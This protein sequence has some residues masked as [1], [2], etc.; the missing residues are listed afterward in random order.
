MI[1]KKPDYPI[2]VIPKLDGLENEI[3][4]RRLFG[5]LIDNKFLV[6]LC[7]AV[8][9]LFGIAYGVLSTPI[10]KSSAL[11][12][13]EDNSSGVLALDDIG[14]MFA[15]N[16][17]VDTELYILKSRLVLGQT[18]DELGLDTVIRPNYFPFVGKFLSRSNESSNVLADPL[19]GASYAWGGEKLEVSYLEVPEYLQFEELTLVTEG[20][21]SYSLWYDGDKLLTGQV[22]KPARS[23]EFD[24]HIKISK[25]F[26]HIGTEFNIIKKSRLAAIM[27]L[28]KDFIA[29]SLGKDTGIMELS[30][31]GSKRDRISNILN[32]ISSNY[33]SQ[34]VLRLAAEAENSLSFIENQLPKVKTSLVNSEVALNKY[35][36]TR[37]SVDL[38]LETESLLSG[39]VKLESEISTMTL[40]ESEISRRF[41]VQ[42]P[43][44]QSF[45]RQQRDL[46]IQRDQLDEKINGLPETQQKILTLMRDFEVN[47]AIYL[48]LQSKTQELSIVKASMVGNVRVLDSAI[49]YPEADSPK[50]ALL[51]LM[52]TFFGFFASVTY[53]F[54]K[55]AL[56]RGIKNSEVLEANGFSVFGTIPSSPAQNKFDT[57]NARGKVNSTSP[58]KPFLLPI[59]YPAD[60]S[61]EALRAVRTALHFAMLEA[62]NK[63]IMI[64][65]GTQGVGKSF[66]SQNLAIVLAQLGMKVLLVDADLRR[67][68]IHKNFGEHYSP[69][70]SDYLFDVKSEISP[71]KTNIN[72]LDLLPRGALHEIPSELLMSNRFTQLLDILKNKYDYILVDTPPALAVTDPSIIGRHASINLVVAR[73]EMT[74]LKEIQLSV[75]RLRINGVKVDGVIFNGLEYSASNHYAGFAKYSY[76]YE[77]EIS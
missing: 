56:D 46:I 20:A 43:A 29:K 38:T 45:K 31:Y 17:S 16:S 76:T 69:G 77:S 34:N 23:V 32:S 61:V 67:G 48:S 1:D 26:A 72:N 4:L 75:D 24:V 33:V 3:D 40:N 63:I 36:E 70:L 55:S 71:L 15:S 6:V 52:F 28:K 65:S 62:K 18:V 37:D 51:S 57:R 8:F 9:G 59:D 64:T 25:L 30:L 2:D 27:I 7:V 54:A 22:N 5:E 50:K 13:V 58:E 35:R 66:V 14:D 10:Y 21:D 19:W 11:I 49:V 42:H 68:F 53:V 47:Q 73:Y 74:T 12:Q 39:F 41:T 44:Y 60:I